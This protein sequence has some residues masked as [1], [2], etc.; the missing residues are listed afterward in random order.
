MAAAM[1]TL[2]LGRMN[3]PESG[4]NQA[5]I[6]RK[7]EKNANQVR[8]RLKAGEKCRSGRDIRGP[9]SLRESRWHR[10]RTRRAADFEGIGPIQVQSGVKQV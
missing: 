1:S 7:A 3:Q 9:G 8:I 2:I 6:G 5:Q 10:A 4:V